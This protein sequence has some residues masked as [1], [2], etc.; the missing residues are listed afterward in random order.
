MMIGDAS[1]PTIVVLTFNDDV[2][3]HDS[4]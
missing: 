4:A 3:H 2:E 1:Q